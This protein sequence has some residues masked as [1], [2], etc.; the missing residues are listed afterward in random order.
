MG[1]LLNVRR[2]IV[3]RSMLDKVMTPLSASMIMRK[4][5]LRPGGGIMP[6]LNTK[7]GVM[8]WIPPLN[9]WPT[10]PA[11]IPIDLP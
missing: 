6:Q 7:V 5:R 9:L 1:I 10:D 4:P 2:P 11:A 3:R 8:R